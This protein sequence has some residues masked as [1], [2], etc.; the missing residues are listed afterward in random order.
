MGGGFSPGPSSRNIAGGASK[1]APV[2][3]KNATVEPTREVVQYEA[4]KSGF[5]PMGK[6]WQESDSENSQD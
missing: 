6:I 2:F 4:R 1:L 3:N 5:W